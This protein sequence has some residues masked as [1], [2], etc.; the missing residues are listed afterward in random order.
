MLGSYVFVDVV[1]FSLFLLYLV[2]CVFLSCRMAEE[3]D[4]MWLGSWFTVPLLCIC[5][6]FSTLL[7]GGG[8]VTVPLAE[9][10]GRGVI[11]V[12]RDAGILFWLGYFCCYAGKAGGMMNGK[13]MRNGP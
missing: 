8:G 13:G 7:F 3:E 9:G 12:Q 5:V 10:R 4:F 1:F 2:G 6:C 11:F